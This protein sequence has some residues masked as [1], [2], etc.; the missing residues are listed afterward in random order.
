MKNLIVIT[1][2]LLPMLCLS[3]KMGG[4][5]KDFFFNT[6]EITFRN[7]NVKKGMVRVN[8]RVQVLFKENVDAKKE[9]YTYRDIKS[10]KIKID[11]EDKKFCFKIL[12]G[13][14]Q[15]NE[16]MLLQEYTSGRVALYFTEM[17]NSS[18]V[19]GNYGGIP[20]TTGL[21]VTYYKYFL[22]NPDE[23]IVYNLKNGNIYS[24]R[25]Y[26]VASEFFSD[27]PEAMKKIKQKFFKRKEI[28]KLV[29]FYNIECP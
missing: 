7:G 24:K 3:Q 5:S 14:Y 19:A 10:F 15:K 25:F 28:R 1:L 23:D 4:G 8:N 22:G 13:K 20:I 27:C 17:E 12:D 21:T 11:L 29:D 18:A 9:R 26:K 16:I 6:G 2:A